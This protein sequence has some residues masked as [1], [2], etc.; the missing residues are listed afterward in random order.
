[1]GAALTSSPVDFLAWQDEQI[2]TGQYDLMGRVWVIVLE[3]AKGAAVPEKKVADKL[4][5]RLEFYGYD[6]QTGVPLM[7]QIAVTKDKSTLLLLDPIRRQDGVVDLPDIPD[8]TW[9]PPL[10]KKEEICFDP[11]KQKNDKTKAYKPPK[12]GMVSQS[13]AQR[14]R[15]QVRGTRYLVLGPVMQILVRPD[16]IPEGWIL[17]CGGDLRSGHEMELVVNQDSGQAFFYG[18]RYQITRPNG[19]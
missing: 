6:G 1:M 13:L 11:S 9:T 18:G 12:P 15:A 8:P 17:Q 3:A 5:V 14:A 16:G 10:P 2:R 7:P 19:A 4:G